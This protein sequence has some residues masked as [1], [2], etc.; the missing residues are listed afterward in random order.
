[1]GQV[2]RNPEA[3]NAGSR[4]QRHRGVER[5]WEGWRWEWRQPVE[6]S[7]LLWCDPQFRF[8][9]SKAVKV[10]KIVS[11]S[12]FLSWVYM[13]SGSS[14]PATCF[15]TRL[16]VSST[17]SALDLESEGLE[18]SSGSATHWQQCELR[19]SEIL[20]FPCWKME[21]KILGTASQTSVIRLKWYNAFVKCF[22]F[23]IFKLI[24][25]GIFCYFPD[26]Y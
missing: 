23:F 3:E 16:R 20:S 14:L 10:A 4:E 11:P 19:F 22:L 6:I 12:L 18:S 9:P 26:I 24:L 17:A 8:R 7:I 2:G 21:T 15:H 5:V 25:G 13:P 1:M